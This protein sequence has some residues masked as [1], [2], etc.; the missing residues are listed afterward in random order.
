[1]AAIDARGCKSSVL[2]EGKDS[3]ICQSLLQKVNGSALKIEEGVLED[4]RG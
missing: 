1:M 2:E 4:V 3:K